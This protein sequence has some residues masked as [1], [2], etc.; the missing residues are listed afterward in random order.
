MTGE[1]VIIFLAIVFVWAVVGPIQKPVP[2]PKKYY[3][4]GE[5]PPNKIPRRTGP[6]HVVN[7]TPKRTK[8]EVPEEER[9]LT[10]D[11]FTRMMGKEKHNVRF[12]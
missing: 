8:V 10:S 9:T 2:P 12:D 5:E 6:P 3:E 11:T 4:E 1:V 7:H